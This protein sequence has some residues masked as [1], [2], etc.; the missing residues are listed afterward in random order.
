LPTVVCAPLQVCDLAL[1]PGE[2]VKS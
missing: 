1:Q 2:M